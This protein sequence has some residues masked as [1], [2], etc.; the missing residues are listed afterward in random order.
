MNPQGSKA[1]DSLGFSRRAACCVTVHSTPMLPL[2][3]ILLA[4]SFVLG[5]VVGIAIG[6]WGSRSATPQ[7]FVLMLALSAAAV[8]FTGVVQYDAAMAGAQ[9]I[10]RHE[11]AAIGFE[12]LFGAM[13]AM[14][15]LVI[16]ARHRGW[17]PFR[18]VIYRNQELVHGS[19]VAFTVGMLTYLI[20]YP[21]TLWVFNATLGLGLVAGVLLALPVH[22]PDASILVALLNTAAGA[23]ACAVGFAFRAV[24]VIVAGAVIAAAAFTLA[25]LI[26]RDYHRTIRQ[27]LVAALGGDTA[28]P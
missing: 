26:A 13:T 16:A 20:A 19:V 25:R 5:A 11:M 15:A 1:T 2:Y 18:T 6:T 9:F 17:V 8:G 23:A 10:A 14:A 28:A 12:V 7:R 27:A 24:L 4:G 22:E 3:V 21:T